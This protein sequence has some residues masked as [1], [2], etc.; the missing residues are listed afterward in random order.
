MY[1]KTKSLYLGLGLVSLFSIQSVSAQE[2]K[3]TPVDVKNHPITKAMTQAYQT[4]P[5]LHKAIRTQYSTAE[6]VPSALRG[7]R[8]N[9]A[10]N[11]TGS[12]NKTVSDGTSEGVTNIGTI[13]KVGIDSKTNS[14]QSQAGL[15]LS[16]NLYDGWQTTHNIS[17][18]ENVVLAG[19]AGVLAK[20]EDVLTKAA[21]AYLE[22]WQAHQNL[23]LRIT[24]EKFA[25]RSYDEIKAQEEVGE[26]TITDVAETETRLASATAQRVSAEAA[27]DAA[28]ATY[29]KDVGDV[30]PEELVTPYDVAEVIKLPNNMAELQKE[31]MDKNP[32]LLQAFFN[33]KAAE[34]G[35]YASEGAILPNLNFEASGTRSFRQD[36]TPSPR[37]SS[38]RVHSRANDGTVKLTMQIPL[39][40]SGAE[41]SAIRKS[42]QDRY[43]AR[44]EWRIQKRIVDQSVKSFW[45]AWKAAALNV[46][47]FELA[48]KAA[49]VTLEGKR[50][51]YLVGEVTLTDML[52][53]E[54]NLVQNQ[55]SLVEAQKN[56][57]L[58]SYQILGLYGNLIPETLYLDVNRYDLKGYADQVR[59]QFIGTGDLRENLDVREE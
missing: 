44:N 1:H 48:V 25:K 7:W 41:W 15:V 32:N 29:L 45:S 6:Q 35:V 30:A 8:P 33:E 46:K 50:Q 9:V 26:K 17:A 58:N 52:Q 55:T 12:K 47:Q 13:Q 10:V 53:A 22:L 56:Y 18:A 38:N 20:E 54:S 31:S 42:N 37:V 24:S 59:G 11:L 40:Q 14:T 28:K 4:N 19:E 5:E 3:T 39:Y 21:S 43:A 51:E 27:L 16:Q 49:E 36:G 23:E 2:P 57:Y 34:Q